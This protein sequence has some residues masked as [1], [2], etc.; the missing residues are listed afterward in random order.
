[1]HVFH[2]LRAHGHRTSDLLGLVHFGTTATSARSLRPV[3]DVKTTISC[4]VFDLVTMYW[5]AISISSGAGGA[6]LRRSS[7][8]SGRPRLAVGRH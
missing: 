1:M 6:Y 5:Y 8:R 4:A 3:D 2:A 7:G